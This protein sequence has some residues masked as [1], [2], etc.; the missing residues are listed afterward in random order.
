M[1]IHKYPCY[2]ITDVVV[3]QSCTMTKTTSPAGTC[4]CTYA[5]DIIEVAFYADF[6]H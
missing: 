2:F 6:I 4:M 3:E 5:C 1:F